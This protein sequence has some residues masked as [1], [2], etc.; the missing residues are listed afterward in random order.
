MEGV[1]G[2]IGRVGID[3]ADDALMAGV[4]GGFKQVFVQT[5]RQAALAHGRSDDDAIDIDEAWVALAEPEVIRTVVVGVLV[6]GQEEG[7]DVAGAAGVEGLPQEMPQPRGVEPGKLDGMLI[8]E[9]EEVGLVACGNAGQVGQAFVSF[10][11]LISRRLTSAAC[12]CCT[13]WPA[14]STM[15]ISFMLVQA[16][17]CIFS[18]APGDW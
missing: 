18:S 11:N 15:W 7:G 6:E 5:V 16:L 1:G 14:P 12:S 9:G 4:D 3:F 17:F 13:Q 2:R 10:R 8:V